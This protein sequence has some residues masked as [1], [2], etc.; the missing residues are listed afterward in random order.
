MIRGMTQLSLNH[1]SEYFEAILE[2]VIREKGQSAANS[3]EVDRVL[4]SLLETLSTL[5]E[6]SYADYEEFLSSAGGWAGIVDA[7]TLQKNFEE[8]RAIPP[9]PRVEL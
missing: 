5:P 2:R 9:R 3:D 1:L 4:P 7:N 8:S 6:K